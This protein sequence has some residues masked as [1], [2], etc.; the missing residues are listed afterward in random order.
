M[1]STDDQVVLVEVKSVRPTLS[2]RADFASYSAHLAR[3]IKKAIEQLTVTHD[4][5]KAGNPHLNHLPVYGQSAMSALIVVPEP[6][7]MANHSALRAR[8]PSAPFNIAIVSLTELEDLVACALHDHNTKILAKAARPHPGGI[9]AADVR[10]VLQNAQL[11]AG[12]K[13]PRNPMLDA[14]FDAMRIRSR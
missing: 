7:Y 5:W 11:R 9:I 12:G 8:L 1:V 10:G 14:A 13:M 4:L 2:A 6:L 3:D